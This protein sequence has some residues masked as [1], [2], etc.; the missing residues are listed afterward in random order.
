QGALLCQDWPGPLQW[1][2]GKAIPPELYFSADDVETG[3][4]VLG[5][6]SFHF[7][8]YGGGTPRLDDFA[9]V[10][11]ASQAAVIAPHAF[12]ANLPRR[13]LGHERGGALAVVGHVERSWGYS[14]RWG[15]A[16][17]QLRCF[18]DALKILM[19]G[20]PAGYALEF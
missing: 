20:K 9:H 8:C 6:V 10:D 16:G 5:L 19:Q 17:R 14:F 1:P 3:S 4:N 12:V 15:G 11:F 13:L 18:Q 2:K 7:A